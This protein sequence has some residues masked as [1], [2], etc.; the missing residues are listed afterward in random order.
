MGANDLGLIYMN[1][2]YYLPQIGRFVSP[3]TMVPE[4]GNPQSYN[5]Y[6]YVRNNP[7][8]FTDPSGHMVSDGCDLD[9]CDLTQ[10]ERRQSILAYGKVLIGSRKDASDVDLLAQLMDFAALYNTT[11]QEW[12]ND[13]T[14]AINSTTGRFTL[15]TALG[16][17]GTLGFNDEG[18]NLVYQDRQNQVYH[19]WAYVN[20]TAQSGKS[21]K[22]LGVVGNVFHEFYDPTGVSR[23]PGKAGNSWEDYALAENGLDFGMRLYTGAISPQTASDA[24]RVALTTDNRSSIVHWAMDV[25]PNSWL[26]PN[27]A[28]RFYNGLREWMSGL[29]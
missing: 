2:R 11:A 27:I 4:P 10:L 18:F 21:G 1:A 19:W 15:V 7:M 6:A 16:K 23:E 17:K 29:P 5:R 24:M 22:V 13:L 14:F 28:N 3:D 9:G 8:N 26:N 12:A 20:T 25:I